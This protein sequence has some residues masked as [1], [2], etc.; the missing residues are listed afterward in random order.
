MS[1]MLFE[2]YWFGELDLNSVQYNAPLTSRIL[3]DSIIKMNWLL[4][5]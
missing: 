3:T 4:L 1:K 2:G 5:R